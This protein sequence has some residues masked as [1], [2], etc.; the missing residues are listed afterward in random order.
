[1]GHPFNTL[2]Y[3]REIDGFARAYNADPGVF[4]RHLL[5][6]LASARLDERVVQRL[7]SFSI[8]I[9]DQC[10]KTYERLTILKCL[11]A[12]FR[13]DALMPPE[14][15]LAKNTPL[16]LEV[17]SRFLAGNMIDEVTLFRISNEHQPVPKAAVAELGISQE[18]LP[19]PKANS[20]WWHTLL[21]KHTK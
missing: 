2:D 15:D 19:V 14:Y 8:G 3:T 1:M 18:A 9:L 6:E 4:M 17:L 13:S 16:S 12:Q 11:R 10:E 20:K 7:L 5:T 21:G